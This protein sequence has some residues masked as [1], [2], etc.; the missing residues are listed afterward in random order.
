MAL[1][2]TIL[3]TRTPQ[4]NFVCLGITFH[5][6]AKSGPSSNRKRTGRIR[7][8][9][10][11]SD[12]K[13]NIKKWHNSAQCPVRVSYGVSYQKLFL[14][15]LYFRRWSKACM[16]LTCILGLSWMFGVFYINQESLFMAYF[17]TIFNTLQ[18][19]YVKSFVVFDCWV[20]ALN[21]RR[22]R[23]TLKKPNIVISS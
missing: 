5:V 8:E 9:Q 12:T 14:F 1:S 13:A 10:K 17:F 11:F 19:K 3:N 7:W 2:K 21:T 16:L 22:R 20:L 15:C 23:Y 4:F 18:V 6:M